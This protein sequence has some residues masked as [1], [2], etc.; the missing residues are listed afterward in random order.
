[1]PLNVFHGGRDLGRSDMRNII[2]VNDNKE[3][4]PLGRKHHLLISHNQEMHII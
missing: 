1:M 4:I 3:V 2:P